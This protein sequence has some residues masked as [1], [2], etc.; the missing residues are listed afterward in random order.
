MTLNK[1]Y[2]HVIAD[3][4]LERHLSDFNIRMLDFNKQNFPNHIVIENE[5]LQRMYNQK[6]IELRFAMKKIKFYE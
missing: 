6:S 3:T 5:S 4:D 2:A 1:G